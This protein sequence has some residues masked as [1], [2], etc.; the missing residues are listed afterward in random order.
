MTQCAMCSGASDDGTG[1]RDLNWDFLLWAASKRIETI[2]ECRSEARQDL[3]SL[4]EAM[5]VRWGDRRCT[6]KNLLNEVRELRA[7]NERADQE[8]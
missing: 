6:W 4:G 2:E 1:G 7:A 5:G 8:P 3:A